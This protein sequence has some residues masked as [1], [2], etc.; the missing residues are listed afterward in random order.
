MEGTIKLG[1]W[2][3]GDQGGPDFRLVS[4]FINGRWE[5]HIMIRKVK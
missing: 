1:P 5:N 4:E 3:K 2:E